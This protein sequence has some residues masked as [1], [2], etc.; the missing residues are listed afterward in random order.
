MGSGEA[1]FRLTGLGVQV[2]KGQ[3]DGGVFVPHDCL[4]DPST[5][6]PSGNRGDH[7]GSTAGQVKGCRSEFTDKHKAA[8]GK[9]PCTAIVQIWAKC[10]ASRFRSKRRGW[11]G[12]RG[13]SGELLRE[14]HEVLLGAHGGGQ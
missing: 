2:R 5:L 9:W 6:S 4:C 14:Q 13:Y 11:G 10:S 7:S 12:G 3:G 8:L 1:T